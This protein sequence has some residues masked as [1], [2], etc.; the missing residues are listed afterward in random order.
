[1]VTHAHSAIKWRTTQST[2][3]NALST[4]LYDLFYSWG[5]KERWWVPSKHLASPGLW[6]YALSGQPQLHL[7]KEDVY[8]GFHSSL[9]GEM[10][11]LQSKGIGSAS[12]QAE[13][14][15]V[16]EEEM[17]WRRKVLNPQ[18]LLYTVFFMIGFYFALQSG[19]EHQQL[20]YNPR[21]IEKSGERR[22]LLYTED[23]LKNRPGRL[24]GRKYKPKVVTH[25]A[26]SKDPRCFVHIFKK[27][28]SL[29]PPDRPHDAFYLPSEATNSWSL[30]LLC[31]C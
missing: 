14:L 13:P 11:H 10:K 21:V 30:V 26:D 5:L 4:V 12:R 15:T 23:I 17:L 29:C 7:F 9:D 24:K 6:H 22:H 19:D 1:M 28:N 31:T 2:Q 16:E 18:S 27:Y 25:Y 20:R 3:V 8:A